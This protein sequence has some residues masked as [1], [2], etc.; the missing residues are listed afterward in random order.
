MRRDSFSFDVYFIGYLGMASGQLALA[1]GISLAPYE[2]IGFEENGPVSFLVSQKDLYRLSP[3]KAYSFF[4][5]EP[6]Q[7][8]VFPT[9]E[10][11]HYAFGG[12]PREIPH[13][14]DP[15]VIERETSVVLSLADAL[16]P[17]PTAPPPGL[18][19]K[20]PADRK[21]GRPKPKTDQQTP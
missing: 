17:A 15:N 12:D 20:K 7:A 10:I 4:L 19:E 3:G 16:W 2:P 18:V 6:R 5:L 11:F 9:K 8:F 21:A 1:H 14:L 13:A